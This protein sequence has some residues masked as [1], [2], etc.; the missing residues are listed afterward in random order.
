MAPVATITSPRR[1]GNEKPDAEQSL[2]DVGAG[3]SNFVLGWLFFSC[4]GPCQHQQVLIR[5]LG[6]CELSGP[7][8]AWAGKAD[9]HAIVRIELV[10]AEHRFLAARARLGH[11]EFAVARSAAAAGEMLKPEY[12]ARGG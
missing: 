6:A 5:P 11:F 7:L 10:D 2:R 3:F 9:P 12:A 1:C 8:A 4:L